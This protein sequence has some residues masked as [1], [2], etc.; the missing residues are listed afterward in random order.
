MATRAQWCW[1]PLLC[2]TAGK[3]KRGFNS[4]RTESPPADE[5]VGSGKRKGRAKMKNNFVETEGSTLQSN[6]PPPEMREPWKTPMSGGGV[7]TTV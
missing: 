7:K 1:N 2:S 6:K 3:R 4:L 5:S